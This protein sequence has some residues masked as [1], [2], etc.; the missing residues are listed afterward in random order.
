MYKE[1]Y[2]DEEL[3]AEHKKCFHNKKSLEQSKE[4]S[5]FYCL[6]DFSVDLIVMWTDRGDTAICPFCSVDAV[7][8]KTDSYLLKILH[9][10]YFEHSFKKV[11]DQW[12]KVTKNGEKPLVVH[13]LKKSISSW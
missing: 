12:V 4:C 8:P 5:C 2:S 10:K 11:K 13:S 6:R 7:I 1:M 3:R 9:G